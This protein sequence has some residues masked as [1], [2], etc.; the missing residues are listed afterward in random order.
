MLQHPELNA[1]KN[2]AVHQAGV[3]RK[4]SSSQPPGAVVRRTAPNM[5]D[6]K[7]ER[8]ADAKREKHIAPWENEKQ[9]KVPVALAALA[10]ITAVG[11][12]WVAVDD[13]YKANETG[14]YSPEMV[15]VFMRSDLSL[16]TIELRTILLSGSSMMLLR[17]ALNRWMK[18]ED[19]SSVVAIL[20]SCFLVPVGML[21]LYDY[22]SKGLPMIVTIGSFAPAVVSDPDTW[23]YFC[24]RMLSGGNI[25]N[26][27]ITYELVWELLIYGF[28]NPTNLYHHS[29]F[30]TMSGT[31]CL[32][33]TYGY[34]GASFMIMELSTIP[35][36]IRRL[37]FRKDFSGKPVLKKIYGY[38]TL[39]F[40]VTF[41][42]TRIVHM[43]WTG[44]LYAG[45][46]LDGSLTGFSPGPTMDKVVGALLV[47]AFLLQCFWFFLILKK[48]LPKKDL[49]KKK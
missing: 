28:S 36:K 41:V 17:Y 18:D 43:G 34:L 48:C 49:K 38:A 8:D 42:L 40:A 44:Y 16:P 2:R 23:G 14:P 22:Y 11:L 19:S 45:W 47:A 10:I 4:V 33:C 46:M 25:F 15:N 12:M 30:L 27:Y 37:T 21:S 3:V 20:F 35:L 9:L 39:A 6:K 29:V 26:G 24:A 7:R 31:F 5:S 1:T 32:A 13:Y